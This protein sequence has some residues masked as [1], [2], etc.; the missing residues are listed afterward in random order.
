M[1]LEI[2]CSSDTNCLNELKYFI[3]FATVS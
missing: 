3:V 1:T 2:E